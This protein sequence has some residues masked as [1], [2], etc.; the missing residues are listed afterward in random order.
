MRRHVLKEA[1]RLL[2]V[3][4]VTLVGVIGYGLHAWLIATEGSWSGGCGGWCSAAVLA[5]VAAAPPL[6]T[7]DGVS[8]GSDKSGA[9]QCPLCDL[10]AGYHVPT[11]D[12]SPSGFAETPGQ[13]TSAAPLE[14]PSK[15]AWRLPPSRGP[16]AK[17]PLRQDP[18]HAAVA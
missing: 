6:G 14:A 8:P 10:L 2:L 3:T 18:S 13:G 15:P 17:R 5:K 12:R 11:L 16:P 9:D 7:T 1:I 4:I